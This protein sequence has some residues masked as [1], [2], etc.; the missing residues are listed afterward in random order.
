MMLRICW[1]ILMLVT[2]HNS[3][4]QTDVDNLRYLMSEGYTLSELEELLLNMPVKKSEKWMEKRGYTFREEVPSKK[5]LVFKKGEVVTLYA[6][7]SGDDITE[8]QV[9]SSPQKY[10]Q[11]AAAF[12]E[13][14]SYAEVPVVK[15]SSVTMKAGYK[16]W[17]RNQF[18]LYSKEADAIIGIFYNYPADVKQQFK[19]SYLPALTLVKGG[20]F[21]MGTNDKEADEKLRPAWEATVSDFYI[22]TYEVTVRE[23]LYFCKLTNRKQPD[24]PSY[25]FSD[26][27]PIINITWYDAQDYCDW[28]SYVTGKK[29]RLPREA[30]WEF[31]AKGGTKSKKFVYAGS[32]FLEKVGWL[33]PKDK[34][35]LKRVGTMYA[36]ELGLYDMSANV[37]EW[38]ADWYDKEYYAKRSNTR[39]NDVLLYNINPKG[40]ATGTSKIL[41]GGGGE[42]AK[43]SKVINR[44]M[45]L[46]EKFYSDVGFR[47][48]MEAK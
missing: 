33:H 16:Y 24:A 2:V 14:G 48:V 29:Y 25:G 17:R 41:R 39:G 22:G 26:N 15:K 45:S 27:Y 13:R 9:Q 38:C 12:K 46:P 44:L 42:E 35:Q 31:A 43:R 34:T 40:A 5:C 4:S 18:M 28:L 47:I 30:E 3:Y 21:T 20:E 37:W 10:Y 6:F 32:D 23:Y 36:N 7:Y 11:A 19:S 1:M 8:I